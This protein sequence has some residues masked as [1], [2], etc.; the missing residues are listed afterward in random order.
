[1]NKTFKK[2]LRYTLTVALT[3]LFTWYLVRAVNKYKKKQIGISISEKAMSEFS[4]PHIVLCMEVEEK[5][6]FI[7]AAKAYVGIN[8]TRSM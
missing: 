2:L 4:L 6:N 7:V 3:L 8:G 5:A 1:M